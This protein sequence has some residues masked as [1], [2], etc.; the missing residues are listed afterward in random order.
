MAPAT[1]YKLMIILLSLWKN[2]PN[3]RHDTFGPFFPILRCGNLAM[4]WR[5]LNFRKF[6]STNASLPSTR[7]YGSKAI[8]L[9]RTTSS[10]SGTALNPPEVFFQ[11][12]N[13]RTQAL[14]PLQTGEGTCGKSLG[15]NGSR[16]LSLLRVMSTP[17]DLNYNLS[18]NHR[19]VSWTG[20]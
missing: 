17:L 9:F 15:A 18:R 7:R 1:S 4:I 3:P 14:R 6:L 2:Q 16:G 10:L 12:R 8:P 5:D 13:D 19:R 20:I 11:L